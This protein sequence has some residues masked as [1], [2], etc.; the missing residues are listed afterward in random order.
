MNTNMNPAINNM[1][2]CYEHL[3]R[4][5]QYPLCTIS[6]LIVITEIR[7][8]IRHKE[9]DSL[10]KCYISISGITAIIVDAGTISTVILCLLWVY[11]VIGIRNF[12]PTT[13]NHKKRDCIFFTAMI[14]LLV[15]MGCEIIYFAGWI[16][17]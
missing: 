14:L 9:S 6:F 4:Y 8:A 13:E 15:L 3:F 2:L 17:V 16:N 5:I 10:A 7:N 11:L 1:I 12:Y